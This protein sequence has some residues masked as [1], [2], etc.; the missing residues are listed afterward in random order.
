M[1]SFS[2]VNAFAALTKKDKQPLFLGV[3]ANPAQSQH[4]RNAC[5]ATAIRTEAQQYAR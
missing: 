4:T 5:A 3:M 2:H 1:L